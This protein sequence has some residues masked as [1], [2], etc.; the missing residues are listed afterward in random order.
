MIES[1]NCIQL[2]DLKRGDRRKEVKFYQIL[3]N[4]YGFE[5]GKA[6]G[7]FGEKTEKATITFNK[8]F[9]GKNTGICNINTWLTLLNM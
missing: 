2:P 4:T 8:K 6:D 9:L 3:L 5:C 1:V 7:I